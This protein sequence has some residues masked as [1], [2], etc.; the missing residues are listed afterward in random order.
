MIT[1]I[2]AFAEKPCN[3]NQFYSFFHSRNCSKFNCT[4]LNHTLRKLMAV[5]PPA[6]IL[7]TKRSSSNFDVYGKLIKYSYLSKHKLC[8]GTG[9]TITLG[10]E[11]IFMSL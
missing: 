7:Q 5:K 11:A 4:E 3:L 9:Y 8:G 10:L 2:D 6:Q 1:E